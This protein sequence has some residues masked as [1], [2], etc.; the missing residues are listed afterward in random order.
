MNTKYSRTQQSRIQKLVILL[1]VA[2]LVSGA[3]LPSIAHARRSWIY[4]KPDEDG[5]PLPE[6][7]PGTSEFD[8][9]SYLSNNEDGTFDLTSNTQEGAEAWLT[10]GTKKYQ[11][12]EKIFKTI[13]EE[14][15]ASG[16]FAAAVLGN[17][18]QESEFNEDAAE[19]GQGGGGW[20]WLYFG[21]N[22]KS[23]NNI[24][25]G[26][27]KPA[28]HMFKWYDSMAGG[29][30]LIG[31]TPYTHY[32]N[33]ANWWNANG[34][35]GWDAENQLKAMWDDEFRN[36]AVEM[37]MRGGVNSRGQEYGWT[38]SRYA[39]GVKGRPQPFQNV[40]QWLSTNNVEEAAEVF[41]VAYLRPY[42]YLPER[43][44]WAKQ[45]NAVFNKANIPAN[46]AKWDFNKKSPSGGSAGSGGDSMSLGDVTTIDANAPGIASMDM[47]ELYEKCGYDAA[48]LGDSLEW[49][50]IL[51]A[52]LGMGEAS[53]T[54][55]HLPTIGTYTS[56]FGMRDSFVLQDGRLGGGGMHYGVDI[57]NSAGTP[58]YAAEAGTVTF[59]GPLGGYG[60]LIKID[61]GNGMETRYA[62]LS[63][64][65]VQEGAKVQRG[66]VI[67]KMG[68]TGDSTGNHLHFEV[69]IDTEAE[70]PMK[71]LADSP[72]KVGAQIT[73]EMLQASKVAPDTGHAMALASLL[74]GS[75]I[76][77]GALMNQFKNAGSKGGTIVK[78]AL[79]LA[80][81]NRKDSWDNNGLP[82]YQQAYKNLLTSG[83]D[84]GGHY[85]IPQS[86][87][88]FVAVTSRFSQVD[89]SYPPGTVSET[90]LGYLRSAEGRSK[91]IEMP[92][93]GDPS[94][95]K[96]GDIMLA[97]KASGMAHGHTGIYVGEAAAKAFYGDKH[98]PGTDF[99]D[100]SYG[101][102]GG[103]KKSADNF[104]VPVWEKGGRGPSMYKLKYSFGEK[105]RQRLIVFRAK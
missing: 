79:S 101:E 27:G 20:Q 77:I 94:M 78:A 13:T 92:Y 65:D 46:R 81:P 96:P 42:K 24:V 18:R 47:A 54:H 51:L 98:V 5:C 6:G 72:L 53:L 11:V 40:E 95:L 100:A 36:K 97:P 70:D 57:A 105:L 89:P 83:K 4:V 1:L 14:W 8:L 52:Q 59:A 48:L 34:K 58:I 99:A 32:T 88:R 17:V 55:L 91:W 43:L 39:S 87:D 63:S 60:N 66:D 103:F 64:I 86:C 75:S 71:Y 19:Y 67:A 9:E 12:A 28:S 69:R 31:W 35:G 44:E 104:M 21:I 62:H 10:P 25:D 50:K 93:N 15:G 3:I 73:E 41:M 76:N 33:N 38:S 16:A 2:I 82:I 37:Y 30:G 45:A 56:K 68:T 23:H 84:G 22:G 90:Q 80:Y 74:D 26:N 85:Y 7:I 49:L 102:K 61:H 29:G